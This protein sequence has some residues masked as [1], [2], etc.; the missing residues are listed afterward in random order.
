MFHIP[1]SEVERK[2]SSHEPRSLIL[3]TPL[4]HVEKSG[5]HRLKKKTETSNNNA[6]AQ[7]I[8]HNAPEDVGNNHSQTHRG[9]Q[10]FGLVFGIYTISNG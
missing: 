4:G 9:G 6:Q 1:S 8:H 2:H 10:Y 3:H 7:Y 5:T